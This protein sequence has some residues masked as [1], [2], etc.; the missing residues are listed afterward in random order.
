MYSD[1][2]LVR[3]TVALL[4]AHGIRHAVVCAGSRNAPLAHTLAAC[5]DIEALPAVDERSA[6]FEAL[7]MAQVLREPVAVCVTSG[8]AL[9]DASPAIAEAYYQEVPLV[10]ISA[11]RPAAWIDQRDGQTM[12]Q[13]GA[14]ASFVRCEVQLPED[15]DM[16]FANRLINQALLAARGPVPGPVHINVP[17]AEPLFSATV[18]AL[19]TP[20]VIAREASRDFAFSQAARDELAGCQNILIIA[21]QM[22]QDT[23]AAALF[24]K[25][26]ARGCVVFAEHL[27]NLPEST[28]VMSLTDLLLAT[29][30]ERELAAVTPDLVVTV[31]GHIFCKRVKQFLR[32][33]DGLRHWHVSLDDTVPDL[34]QHLT[35]LLRAGTREFLKAFVQALDG[36]SAE[37]SFTRAWQ[38]GQTR[39]R[40]ALREPLFARTGFSDLAVM[41]AFVHVLPA[42]CD[43]HLANSSPVRNAQYFALPRDTRVFCNRGV[44]GIDGSLSAALGN[45]RASDR[46]V[47]CCIGDLSFFYDSNALWRLSLPRNLRILVFN[48]GGGNIFRCLPGL[49]SPHRDRFIAG[50]NTYSASSQARDAGLDYCSAANE[51]EC[52]TA[53]RALTAAEQP[54][55]L[56]VMT[57]PDVCAAAGRKLAAGLRARADT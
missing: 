17:L 6:C 28:P 56:E 51:Q 21:G 55:L 54:T 30:D 18:P 39:L 25:C 15:H 7:G 33:V 8:S 46:T 14:L 48:N 47:Y 57:A 9:L 4:T 37:T 50:A 26:A 49:N 12:R 43:L 45:A 34:F 32:T 3:E 41:Q 24:A 52:L 53:L 19:G 2:P 5:P 29:A 20:R 1:N 16:W 13:P 31:G 10:L 36:R 38:A 27:A 40:E 23:E 35:R 42:G 11:D 44:N 22:P